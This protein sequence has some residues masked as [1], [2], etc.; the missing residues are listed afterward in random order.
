MGKSALCGKVKITSGFAFSSGQFS[1]TDGMPLLRIRD[2]G[3]K[4][5]EIRFKGAFDPS[6]VIEPGDVLIGM[7]GDFAVHRWAGES[8]L[9]N[10]RVCKVKTAS[11]ELDQSFLYWYLH[12][13]IARIHGETPETTVRHLSTKDVETI[14]FPQLDP[15]EQLCVARILDIVDTAIR[16]TEAIIEK[17]KQVKQGLLHDLLTRGI[18]ENGELRPPQSEAPHLY[19]QSPLG[20]IPKEWE[21]STIGENLVEPP[22]N[23]LYKPPSL[24]GR[25]TL[26][27]GQTA[28]TRDGSVDFSL[29][30]RAVATNKELDYFHLQASDLLVTRVYATPSGVGLPYL[31]P[32]LNE[33]AVYESNMMR[34]RSREENMNPEV[35]FMWLRSEPMR[36]QIV[37]TISTSNQ[38]S[39]NQAALSSITIARPELAEQL[40]IVGMSARLSSRQTEELKVLRQLQAL[41]A[42]L[43]SDLLTGRDRVTPLLNS[44]S[45]H[46]QTA[47]R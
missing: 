3:N 18:D 1:Q 33:P 44:G 26:L 22:R 10:Q 43:M 6:Y 14:P 46:P 4:S 17:L 20:W 12:P 13:H 7:D 19:K 9:L 38:S 27:I 42:G 8:A 2:L 35:L 5:T 37:A 21:I 40:L 15:A 34:L 16:Q 47:I 32:S 23:G 28:F 45:D 25:G 39:I 41:K 31:V 36:R 24:I 11:E 29:A 30:R